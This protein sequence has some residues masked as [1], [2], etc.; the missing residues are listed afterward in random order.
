M[1]TY[2]QYAKNGAWNS[3]GTLIKCTGWPSAILDGETFEFIKTVNPPGGHH[4]WSHTQPNIIYGTN[5]PNYDGNCIAQLDVNTNTVT[6]VRCFNEYTFVSHGEWEGNMSNDDRYMALQCRLPSNDVVIACYDFENDE[7]VSTLN[8]PIW[9]NNVTM[10]Q[11]GDY[12]IVQW[13]VSGTNQYQGVWAYN[14][15]DMSPVR[16]LSNLGG[17]H[18]DYGYDTQGNEVIVGP[19]SLDRRLTMRRIDNGVITNLLGDDKMSWYIHV[20]CRNIDRPGWAYLTEFADPN[21]QTFKPNYQKMFAVQLNPNAN[22]NALTE[23]FAHVHHSPN[24][25]YERSPFGTSNRDGTKVIFRSDWMGDASSEINSYV[26]FMP[27]PPTITVSCNLKVLLEGA[28]DA[29]TGTMHNKLQQ[30]ESLPSGQPYTIVPWNHQGTEGAGWQGNDYPA[31]TVDWVLVSFRKSPLPSSEIAK[32]ATI[33]LTDGNIVP[34]QIPVSSTT[35]S[36]YIVVEHRNHLPAMSPMPLDIVNN[37]L[38]YDFSTMNSYIPGTEYGQKLL[39]GH[40]CLFAGNGVQTVP[41]QEIIGSDKVPWVTANGLFE[42]YFQT[43]YNMDSDVNGNDKGLWSSN[44]G[45]FSGVE[46]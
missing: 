20:S 40:W 25:N 31:N 27:P 45:I 34:V 16:N 26:A 33:L 30:Y 36:L 35:N 6:P 5:N 10:T 24:V 1:S 28:L 46:Q 2:H 32:V 29:T 4:T 3:D 42:G 12:V 44:N 19:S 9:P 11:S 38:T 22:N 43:D 41:Y 8:A 15:N 14:R 17:S 23:T 18:F 21:T 13:G 37:T 7:I 39:N